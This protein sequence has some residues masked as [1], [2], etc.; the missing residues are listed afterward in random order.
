MGHTLCT[1]EHPYNKICYSMVC[2]AWQGQNIDQ[3]K[4]WQN[5]DHTLPTGMSYG[6]SFVSM[7][8]KNGHVIKWS[9]CT[10]TLYLNNFIDIQ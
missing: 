5:I 6:V 10:C 2:I 9:A 4:N 8:T 3:T 7:L 1:V